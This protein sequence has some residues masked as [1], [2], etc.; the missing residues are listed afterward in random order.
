M[1]VGVTEGSHL[2]MAW[3]S[4]QQNSDPFSGVM[5][6]FEQQEQY[7]LQNQQLLAAEHG[8]SGLTV[9][10]FILQSKI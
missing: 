4:S 7:S 10:E 1:T 6:N 5:R 3:H 9:M 8:K 2:S